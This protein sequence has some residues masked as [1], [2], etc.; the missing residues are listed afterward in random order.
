MLGA[1][2]WLEAAVDLPVTDPARVPGGGK[3]TSA[4]EI[5]EQMSMR[6]AVARC[7]CE[8]HDA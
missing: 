3:L 4:V 1:P 7:V 6:T 5:V 2:L 8:G